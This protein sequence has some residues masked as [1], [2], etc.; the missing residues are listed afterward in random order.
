L[1]AVPSSSPS[2]MSFSVLGLTTLS[3]TRLR[4]RRASPTRLRPRRAQPRPR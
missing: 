3:R 1:R 4:P 2:S